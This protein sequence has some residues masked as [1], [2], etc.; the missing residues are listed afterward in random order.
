[1]AADAVPQ[2]LIQLQQ[3][4]DE[5]RAALVAAPADADQEELGRLRAAERQAVLALTRAGGHRV[6]VVGGAAAGARGRTEDPGR[7][8]SGA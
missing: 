3:Q 1:V 2:H 8:V 5:A 6:R 7:R 4:Y